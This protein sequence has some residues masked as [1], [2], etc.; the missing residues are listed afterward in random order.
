MEITVSDTTKQPPRLF[1]SEEIDLFIDGDR[2]A[3]DRHILHSLNRITSVII[4]HVEVEETFYERL[5]SIGGFESIKKRAEF[6]D[7]LIQ[8]NEK[9]STMAE[10]V[11]QSVAIWA[12]ILLI[13]F[14]AAQTWGGVVATVRASLGNK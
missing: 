8:R 11:A 14:I 6:I 13:G 4:P 5:E 2:R 7:S 1:T 10:K 9:I 12:V 3:I